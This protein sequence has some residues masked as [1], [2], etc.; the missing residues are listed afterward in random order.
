MVTRCICWLCPRTWASHYSDTEPN[1]HFITPP[2][3]FSNFN[4]TYLVELVFEL[5]G[6]KEKVPTV[7]IA[8]DSQRCGRLN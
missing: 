5:K 8:G 7:L 2:K 4:S 3:H 1:E 6:F